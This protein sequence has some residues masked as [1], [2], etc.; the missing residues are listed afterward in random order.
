MANGKEIDPVGRQI[1]SPMPACRINLLVLPFQVIAVPIK[2]SMARKE[3]ENEI[4]LTMNG[5]PVSGRAG[6]TILEVARENGID[7]PTLCH[8]S[9]L[10]PSGVCRLCVVEVA[11]SRT[12]VG[13]CHTPI[14][15]GMMVATHSPKILAARKI[16][17]EL[18]MASHPDSCLICDKANICEL[19]NIAAD[20]EIGLPRFRARKHYYPLEY[21]NPNIIRDMSKCILCRRCVV[22]CQDL[23]GERLFS[24][25]Y[26]GFESKVV[27]GCDQPVDKEACQDCDECITLCPSG[28]LRRPRRPGEERAK[29]ALFIKG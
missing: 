7:I 3:I 23:K 21:E 12:L 16:L 2:Q 14:T 25:A 22:A 4:T 28:A 9:R 29:K 18:L 15:E 1:C 5:S 17:V 10:P 6:M 11:G 26:R 27:S 19:R 20:L 24:V 8:V 13:A